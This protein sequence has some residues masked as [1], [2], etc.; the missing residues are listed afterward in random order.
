MGSQSTAATIR[1]TFSALKG[2]LNVH[3]CTDT[4]R[5]LV[6]FD[7]KQLCVNDIF[8]MILNV[9]RQTSPISHPEK[10]DEQHSS[11]NRS[12][13][14]V[15][16]YQEAA[17]TQDLLIT[18]TEEQ[19]HDP[20]DVSPN[21]DV[22][23]HI[24]MLPPANGARASPP[25]PIPLP[26]SLAMGGL[27]F[28]GAKQLIFGK[29]ALARSPVPFYLSGLVSVVTGYPFIK[30]GVTEFG[31]ERKINTDLVLGAGALALALVR[32]NLVVLA[33]LSIL[34][35]VNWR[36]SGQ[37]QAEH[38]V[39]LSPEIRRYSEKAGKLGIAAAGLTWALTR[40]PLRGIAVLLAANPR[41]ASIPAEAAWKQAEVEFREQCADTPYHAS[42][43]RLPRTRTLLLEDTSL[44]FGAERNELD[45]VSHEDEPD[46]VLCSAASLMEKTEHPWKEAVWRKAKESCRTIRT[47]FHVTAEED[48]ITGTVQNTRYRLGTL[49]YCQKHEAAIGNYYLE[50]KRLQKKGF[51]VLFV[52]KHTNKGLICVGLIYRQ[53]EIDPEVRLYVERL[54]DQGFTLAPLKHSAN[55]RPELVAELGMDPSWLD[56]SEGDV[57]ERSAELH[58]RDEHVLLV[59]GKE[60]DHCASYLKEAGVAS[61]SLDQ[62]DSVLAAI[63]G[64]RKMESTVQEHLQITKKWN[65]L[66]TALA[67]LG[68]ITAPLVNLASDALSLLFLSRSQKTAVAAFP[69]VNVAASEMAT[70][71]EALIWHSAPWSDIS[72]KFNVNESSGLSL[73]QVRTRK[74]QFGPN[75]LERKQPVPWIKSY[76]GQFK[77][78]TTLVLVGTSLLA[79]VTGG[80]FDGLAMGAVLLANAAISTYQ[81]RKA[82]KVLEDLN[83]FQ[84]SECTVLRGGHQERISA[85]G[86]VPGDLVMLE[87]GDRVPADLRIVRAWNLEVNEAALTGES[88]P[89]AKNESVVNEDRPL[90]ERSNMLYMGTDISRGKALGVVVA[91]G[92]GT[93][94]GHLMSLLKTED[95][96]VTPLQS[97]V[98]SISKTFIKWAFLAGSLVFVTGLLRGIPLTQMISTSITL[99]ASAIPEGLP[100]T[101]TIALSAGIF[102]MAKK[103]VHVRKLSALETLGRTTVICSDKTG[104][105]TKNEM[106]VKEIAAIGHTWSVAGNGYSPEGTIYDKADKQETPSHSDSQ[107]ELRRIM[108]I[109]VLC[110]NSAM[111]MQDQSWTVRGD[112]TEAALLFMAAKAGIRAENMKDWHRCQ[113]IPFD[114]G[115]GRMSVVCKHAAFERECYLF[116]KGAVENILEHC[117]MYQVDGAVMPITDDIRSRIIKQNETLAG[118]AL[119]VLGFAYCSVDPTNI[120]GPDVVHKQMIYVG[121]AGM[122][123]PPKAGVEQS[124]KEARSIGVKPVMITGDHPITAVAIAKQIGIDD[125]NCKVLSG[126]ELDRLTDEELQQRVEEITIFARVTP[127]QKLRI[128]TAYQ[129][130]GHTVAMTGDGVNDSPAIKKA[131]VG[132]AMGKT[133]TDVTKETADIVL[134]EDHFGSI[135]EGVKEGRKIIGNIRKALGCLLT[136]NLAEILVTSAAVMVGL[137]IPLVPIQI[138]LMNLL[139]DTLPAMVLAINPGNKANQEK[140][141]DI[142]DKPL[143]QKVITRGVLLGAGSLGLFTLTLAGGAS[144]QVAQSVAFAT[145]VAGQLIQTMN[146]RKEGSK[147][148]VRDISKDRFM[149]GALGAS[150]LALLAA[151]YVPPVA[152]F[153]HTAPL[154]F[155]HWTLILS[156]AASV[157]MLSK[158]VLTYFS[159]ST[160]ADAAAPVTAY[161]A[162]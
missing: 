149:L 103:N 45:C 7:E 106:T 110:N 99:A 28:L 150:W 133:G 29:S 74:R 71:A 63:E 38:P 52:A 61:S 76:L 148:T 12:S 59:T 162:A 160:S 111:E 69:P 128:V 43:S 90:S 6:I 2:V 41:P 122:I 113:E 115:T 139:T 48:G 15:G 129:Q 88:L 77:E 127:E 1:T 3:P 46:R 66:G 4:G 58:Q 83:R 50:A 138:L 146:W 62:L 123:D 98:T 105:L 44:M 120:P 18:R 154:S 159:K 82:E 117:S 42:L 23:K 49:A 81:E 92:M 73:E 161:A 14:P 25:S 100:V 35:Y 140:R 134:Q 157:S 142:V 136:G 80:M 64:A 20:P 9:E 22:T 96:E 67:T 40:D 16:A 86:L 31:K 11:C 47:A 54:R 151:L 94:I 158:P 147:E 116:S 121:M 19:E 114:S 39:E 145:L 78:F 60:P 132:I 89:I 26:L 156:V 97:K 55:V 130:L 84:P 37:F 119:R 56:L 85:V 53:Q 72:G 109:A 36:R 13:I 27:A 112:P 93:E 144:V 79:F 141:I 104:T 135:V 24:R 102:R 21:G 51:D 65:V 57:I 75:E 10:A 33:G 91:T 17:V 34:Q 153:F 143:Y 108:Q 101:I 118:D 125:E 152:R 126:Y 155:S 8:H 137:P 70:A 68:V 95:K 87:A 131:D 5:V 32:E 107:P 124:I 30:R